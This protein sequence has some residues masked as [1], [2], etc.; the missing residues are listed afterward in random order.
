MPARDDRLLGVLQKVAPG[1]QL[2]EGIDRIIKSNKGAIIL[3]GT[4][5]EVQAMCSGGFTLRAPF[6]SQRLSEVAKMDGAII[7]DDGLERIVQAGV[8]LVP[9][10][11]IATEETGIRHRT[12]ER[13]AKQTGVEVVSVSETMHTVSLYVDRRKHVLEDLSSVLFRANQA[14]STLERY[15]NRLDEVN[16]M[17]SALEVDHVVSLRDA[18]T[19]LQRAEMVRRIAAE[20]EAHIAEL[21]TEG[22]LLQLQLDELVAGVDDEAHQVIRDY[23]GDRRRKVDTVVRSLRDLSAADLFDLREIGRALGYDTSDDGLDRSVMPR[24]HRMLSRLPRLGEAV[25]DRIVGH[26]GSLDK[27]MHAGREELA[28]VEGIGPARA[29]SIREG[30][31]RLAEAAAHERW[32]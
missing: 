8:H 9:D 12:A 6:S 17:L 14:L 21:G 10:P 22:R 7:L 4:T 2:R 23:L 27:L 26:F 16:G 32:P 19:V 13:V 24:G 5:D 3:L 25:A 31:D 1:T 30:L 20:I 15:R 29:R 18:V 11:S 28:S